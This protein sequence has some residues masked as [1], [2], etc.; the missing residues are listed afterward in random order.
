MKNNEDETELNEKKVCSKCKE[1]KELGE[2]AISKS[3]KTE[4]GLINKLPSSLY[5]KVFRFLLKN[6]LDRAL[7]TF[8]NVSKLFV[9][10]ILIASEIVIAVTTCK[11]SLSC[12]YC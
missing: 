10:H 7:K 12:G 6:I 1:N 3:S 8:G 2:F 5:P 4:S 9:S 11:Y